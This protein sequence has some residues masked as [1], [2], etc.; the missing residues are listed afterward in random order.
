MNISLFGQNLSLPNLFTK[1]G[2][3]SR[4]PVL[5]GNNASYNPQ[6]DKVGKKV[7][8]NSL[9]TV[10]NNSGDVAGCVKELQKWTCKGGTRFVDPR[11]TDE[12]VGDDLAG[13][14]KEFFNS[15]HSTTPT[16]KKLKD[17]LIF[18]REI[19]GNA[20]AYIIRNV[21]GTKVL[22]LQVMDPRTVSI[23]AD[24]HGTV[25]RYIQQTSSGPAVEFQP[26]EIVHWK[27][28]EHSN[29]PLFGFSAIEPVIWEVQTDLSAMISNY[30]FFENNAIPA[31]TY[32]MD[33]TLSEEEM[34]KAIE[35][36]KNNHGGAENRHK[37]SAL[38]G[39]KEIKQLQLSHKDVEFLEGRKFSRSKVCGAFGVPEFLLGVT[40]KVNNNN[41][42]ELFRKFIEGTI[43]DLEADFASFINDQLFAR[44]GL[45][46]FAKFA[47]VAQQVET[48]EK[49]VEIAL[50]EYKNGAL[51]LRQYKIQTGKDITE[52]D[53]SNPMI[54]Q[55]IIHSGASAIALED[56]GTQNL[57]AAKN[58]EALV[59]LT[60]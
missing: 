10:H 20:Y 39:V 34:K 60:K 54:D 15:E 13:Q 49:I 55:Y 14:L 40:E 25:Y 43:E 30:K 59:A 46:D 42:Q 11:N 50:N 23:V 38:M 57:E 3:K 56:V 22:G 17:K 36:I 27:R 24:A 53:E 4:W 1:G 31:A 33:E 18:D 58:A 44:L 26:E 48:Q 51:T 28:G 16:F 21:M 41:G 52:A 29:N 32:I 8:A 19:S 45:K 9:Y 7:N 5:Y 47:P 6:Q 12:T 35:Y 37:T 2:E